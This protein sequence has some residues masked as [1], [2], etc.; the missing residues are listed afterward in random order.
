MTASL[1]NGPFW[2]KTQ[3]KIMHR[4]SKEEEKMCCGRQGVA[5]TKQKQQ[6]FVFQVNQSVGIQTAKS[7]R[8]KATKCVRLNHPLSEE[9]KRWRQKQQRHNAP[10]RIAVLQ[11]SWLI[12][13]T[14][15]RWAIKIIML[16]L[17]AAAATNSS[18]RNALKICTGGA[19]M[20]LNWQSRRV[21]VEQ[22]QHQTTWAN[23]NES[24]TET[25]NK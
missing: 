5:T 23:S 7:N 3:K 6:Q 22:A 18:V 1:E 20:Q 24:Q 16:R 25:V 2:C 21:Q 17:P 10:V 8:E 14:S 11:M 4:Q 12:S 15:A 13:G 19:H 9:W